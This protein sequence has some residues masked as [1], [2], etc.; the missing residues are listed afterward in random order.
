MAGTDDPNEASLRVMHR[1]G[2][3]FLR[4]T[5]NPR[6]PGV[7]YVRQRADPLPEPVPRTLALGKPTL[8]A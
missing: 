5:Q 1:L 3:R 4:R 7:E 6:W 8:E 2:M